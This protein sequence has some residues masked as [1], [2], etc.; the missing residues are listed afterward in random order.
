[1]TQN[2][3]AALPGMRYGDGDRDRV[4]ADRVAEAAILF[5]VFVCVGTDNAKQAKSIAA[6]GDVDFQSLLG[7]AAYKHS[8]TVPDLTTTV[9]YS[10]EQPMT[11]VHKGYVYGF[12]EE[13]MAMGDTVFIRHAASGGNTIT[14]KVRNDADTASCTSYANVRVAKAC[15]AAGPVLLEIL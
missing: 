13:P 15:T 14:G 2:F 7:V 1:M 8:A 12:A 3:T 5:G 6:A 9:Q 4:I 10:A 11:I